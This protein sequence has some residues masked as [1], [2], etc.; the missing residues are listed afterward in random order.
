[1][2]IRC[3]AVIPFARELVWTTYRDRLTQL[4]PYLP[5]LRTIEVRQRV[6]EGSTV[7]LVNVWHGGGD[8]PP[9]ARAFL[10]ESMLS[11]T[12][13]ATW[14]NDRFVCDWVTET[15]AFTEAVR[16]S[17]SNRYLQVAAGTQLQI[18]GDLS[19][20]ASKIRGVPRLVAGKVG[21]AVEEFLVR[22]VQRNL[23]DVSK[24]IERFLHGAD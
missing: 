1:M 2:Q 12:D 18:R 6:Q 17:G 14:H 4:L 8:I 15:H 20:D 7:R 13:H 5:N 21:R 16:S 23:L 10:S 19:I 11:W 9:I 22:T 3:D 24:G